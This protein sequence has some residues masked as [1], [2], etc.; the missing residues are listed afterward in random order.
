MGQQMKNTQTHIFYAK[1]IDL[2]RKKP[3]PMILSYQTGNWVLKNEIFKSFMKQNK[4]KFI[5]NK[6][7][8]KPT[9]HISELVGKQVHWSLE[10]VY[11]LSTIKKVGQFIFFFPSLNKKTQDKNWMIFRSNQGTP[12]PTHLKQLDFSQ[13]S[14]PMTKEHDESLQTSKSWAKLTCSSSWS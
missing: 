8:S 9:T 12:R 4:L 1:W 11:Q 3:K 13:N 2:L 14:S 10:L 7:T 6:K 5:E